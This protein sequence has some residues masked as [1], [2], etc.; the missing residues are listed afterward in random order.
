MDLPKPLFIGFRVK[1]VAVADWLAGREV[2]SVSD[3]VSTPPPGWI[4]RW[5]FNRAS[6]YNSEAAARD[7]IPAG[8]D[9]LYNLLAYRMYP[10]E[11]TPGGHRKVNLNSR[12]SSFGDALPVEPDLPAFR[13][14]GF[15]VVLGPT[16]VPKDNPHEVGWRVLLG[17]ACSPLSCNSL[18][19]SDEFH[20]NQ[21]YLLDEIDT[22]IRA[23]K[24]FSTSE[25][26]EPGWYFIF[27][28][29]RKEPM[30]CRQ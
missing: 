8:D 1:K 23:A 26:A 9:A 20:V 13:F 17:F 21:Y 18:G 14:I 15:D 10:V 4:Q 5:D 19:D 16:F 6:C 28:V 7:T 11:F 12:L 3:C 24:T 30:G 22:A 29:L 27:E 2:C 25:Q